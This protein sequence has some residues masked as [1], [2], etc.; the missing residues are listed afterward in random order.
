MLLLQTYNAQIKIMGG[1]LMMLSNFSI[2]IS[3]S[4]IKNNAFLRCA[5]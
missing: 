1:A 2:I 5:E 4:I 3:I